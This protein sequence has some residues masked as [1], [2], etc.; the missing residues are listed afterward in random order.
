M[1]GFHLFLKLKAV[2]R[3]GL[4]NVTWLAFG[5]YTWL[6]RL[7]RKEPREIPPPLESCAAEL[8][9]ILSEAEQRAE[10]TVRRTAQNM[11]TRFGVSSQGVVKGV[12][13]THEEVLAWRHTRAPRFSSGQCAGKENRR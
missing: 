6:V 9:Q 4:S 3:R 8:R 10:A 2:Y 12:H 13:E 5:G 1:R 7:T 11:G